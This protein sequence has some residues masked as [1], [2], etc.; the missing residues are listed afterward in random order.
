MAQF[1]AT[2]ES[3]PEYESF[4]AWVKLH[5]KPPPRRGNDGST[6]LWIELD[7]AYVKV[8]SAFNGRRAATA[9]ALR[10]KERGEPAP[11]R[12]E[13]ALLAAH[14]ED[15]RAALES[16]KQALEQYYDLALVAEWLTTAQ[17]VALLGDTLCFSH[18]QGSVDSANN[19]PDF[20]RVRRGRR[21]NRH[22]RRAQM[23]IDPVAHAIRLRRSI[24]INMGH[25]PTRMHAGIR[26]PRPVNRHCFAAK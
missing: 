12:E 18:T 9:A 6:K 16:A 10:R 8:L 14:L 22:R 11:S 3:R 7:N 17:S 5:S 2:S 19:L 26:P 23:K 15:P 25:L 20:T 24:Q 1:F 13:M 4:G 21:A